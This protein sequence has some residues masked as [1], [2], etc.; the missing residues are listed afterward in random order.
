MD[1]HKN[2]ML[3]Y[4]LLAAGVYVLSSPSVVVNSLPSSITDQEK[5]EMIQCLEQTR[6]GISG[7]G[8][9]TVN[10]ILRL[11]MSAANPAD[12]SQHKD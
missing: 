9:S 4:I 11:W 10:I 6:D 8:H 7:L 3:Q 2:S 12:N 5:G 1:I